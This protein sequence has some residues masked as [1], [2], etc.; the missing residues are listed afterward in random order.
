[1]FLTNVHKTDV[2]EVCIPY[3]WHIPENKK[4]SLKHVGG[5]VFMDDLWFMCIC[6]YIYVYIW[7]QA[8]CTEGIIL[9]LI[10]NG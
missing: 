7:L 10:K 4:L 6:W 8:Q 3:C 2:L 1:M 5:F 9:N